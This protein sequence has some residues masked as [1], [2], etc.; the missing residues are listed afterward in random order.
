[1]EDSREFGPMP[2]GESGLRAIRA[3]RQAARDG[4]IGVWGCKAGFLGERSPLVKI[5]PEYWDDY[6]LDALRCLQPDLDGGKT[7]AVHNMRGDELL[8][9]D[10]RMNRREIVGQWPRR[11]L[12]RRARRAVARKLQRWANE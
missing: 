10:L 8:Y 5:P 6:Q 9:Y 1:M 3:V 4:D 2:G 12:L 11:P 7:E